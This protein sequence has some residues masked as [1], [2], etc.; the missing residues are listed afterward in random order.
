MRPKQRQSRINPNTVVL[1]KQILMGVLVF[2]FVGAVVMAVWY[3][4]RISALTITKVTATGGETIDLVYVEQLARTELEGSYLGLVPRRFAWA[5]PESRITSLVTEIPRVSDVV[6]RRESGT[7][8]RI[9][10][11][12]YLPDALWC[13]DVATSTCLL[14]DQRGYPFAPAPALRGGSFLRLV[15]LGTEPVVGELPWSE[16]DYQIMRQLTTALTDQGWPISHVEIDIMRD[17]FLHIVGGG[18]FKMTLTRPIEES[19]SNL[20]AVATAE[21]FSDLAPGTFAYIDLRFGNKV[22]VNEEVQAEI[23]ESAT[24]INDDVASSSLAQDEVSD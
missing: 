8:L 17:I 13:A 19:L 9:E 21:Q 22:F 11:D 12:E 18:E 4:T 7:Q 14:V 16:S 10:V 24:E 2:G 20:A 6:V 1:I 5:Y 23:V 3:G 15:T